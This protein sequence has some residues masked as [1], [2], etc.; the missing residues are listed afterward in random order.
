MYEWGGAGGVWGVWTG[1]HGSDRRLD[2]ALVHGVEGHDRLTLRDHARNVDLGRALRNHLNVDG[3]RHSGPHHASRQP[4]APGER[5]LHHTG[6]GPCSARAANIC[7]A[8]PTAC[9]ICRPTSDIIAM[10]RCTET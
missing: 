7:A 2:E 8:T 5:A 3:Y 9:F 10:S 6:A 4:Q 1:G